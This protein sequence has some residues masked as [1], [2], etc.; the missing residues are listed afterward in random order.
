MRCVRRIIPAHS[1][2]NFADIEFRCDQA[3]GLKRPVIFISFQHLDKSILI[4]K[5]RGPGLVAHLVPGCLGID[6]PVRQQ[7]EKS[8]CG[9]FFLCCPGCF[10]DAGMNLNL[11]VIFYHC[12]HRAVPVHYVTCCIWNRFL[13]PNIPQNVTD[14]HRDSVPAYTGFLW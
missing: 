14:T 9:R 7:A 6:L 11:R 8:L 3:L 4:G 5:K 1:K 13:I 2:S 10:S 12:S